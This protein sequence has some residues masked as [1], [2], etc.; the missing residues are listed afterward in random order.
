MSGL[1]QR[2]IPPGET[3]LY[4]WTADEYGS[5][6]YHAHEFS[7]IVDGLFGPIYVRPAPGSVTPFSLISTDPDEL[8]ALQKAELNTR[9]IQFN[10]WNHLTS[11]ERI[12]VA[13]NSGLDTFCANSMLIN[14]KGS[15]ICLSQ[16]EINANISPV[17]V[18]LLAGM[19]YS[20]IG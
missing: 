20:D 12:E 11:S 10:T 1:T 15:S 3:F 2:A 17:V 14:G 4:R 16:A 13:L 5:Y 18:Q 6:F 8:A 7:Q 19:D 9:P